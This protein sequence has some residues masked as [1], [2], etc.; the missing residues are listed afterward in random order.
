MHV[1]GCD[2][3]NLQTICNFALENPILWSGS[4]PSA[5][6]ICRSFQAMNQKQV[7]RSQ[8]EK[9]VLTGFFDSKNVWLYFITGVFHHIEGYMKSL[10][11]VPMS[12]KDFMSWCFLCTVL[13][14]LEVTPPRPTCEGCGLEMN[15]WNQVWHKY[16]RETNITNGV[17][18]C[19][20]NVWERNGVESSPCSSDNIWIHAIHFQHIFSKPVR[21]KS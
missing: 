7:V 18:R 10:W 8:G 21:H 15:G 3:R 13:A 11:C 19:A 17:L 14:D 1:F 20:Q 6:E 9:P 2:G 12:F 16:S 4:I 5:E